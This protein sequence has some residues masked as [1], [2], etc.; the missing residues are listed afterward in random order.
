[1]QM[2][3]IHCILC[4][5]DEIASQHKR[6]SGH[7]E[8]V[9]SPKSPK[10]E[11]GRKTILFP[12]G[13]QLWKLMHK[14]LS[15]LKIFCKVLYE[16]DQAKNGA[17]GQAE[18]AAGGKDDDDDDNGDDDDKDDGGADDDDENDGIADA[19]LSSEDEKEEPSQAEVKSAEGVQS[20]GAKEKS[21]NVLKTYL[22]PLSGL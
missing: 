4:S 20:A 2:L 17:G 8:E 14:I 5:Q 15:K 21:K 22:Q 12:R 11:L 3:I 7:H 10:S 16:G 6:E 1:M 9:L 13:P 19:M 18:A